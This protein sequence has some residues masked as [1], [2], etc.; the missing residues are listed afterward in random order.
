[1]ISHAG[2]SALLVAGAVFAWCVRRVR[3]PELLEA[4]KKLG[5]LAI[6]RDEMKAL[7]KRLEALKI[8][9]TPELFSA[10]RMVI[11]VLPAI[12]GLFLIFD[13]RMEGAF[14][15]LATPM[16]RRLPD[17]FLNF[18][19]KKRKEELLRDFPL[20]MDQVKIYARAAGYYHAIKIVSRSFKGALGG[21]LAVLSA[22]MEL[23][24]LIEAVNNF[25][26][27]CGIPEIR[28][29]ARIM[30][31]AETTGADI[32]NILVNYSTMARQRQVSRIK[33]KI[34]IQPVLMS[35]LPGVL[36]IIFILMFIIPMVTSIIQQINTIK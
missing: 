7:G 25:A 20:L 12:S 27:R 31:V 21:E 19:E 23:V 30:A 13:R 17:L 5:S 11:T 9:V 16:V 35:I 36:L 14:L 4:V 2:L 10:G 15:L 33:R 32:S 26:A 18:M 34:K 24:G 29:F 28:D 6:D 3:L 8:P 22:E 1:M